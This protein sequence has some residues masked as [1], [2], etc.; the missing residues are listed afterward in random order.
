MT[1]KQQ[2][3]EQVPEA[4]AQPQ[5][6]GPTG[7]GRRKVD[8]GFL[9]KYAVLFVLLGLVV[10]FSIANPQFLTVRNL[11]NI[12]T[13]NTYFIIVAIGLAFV[14]ISGGIDLSVGYQMSLVGVIMAMMMTEWGLPV[15]L[16]L[17]TAI[18]LGTFLGMINGLLVTRIR[19]FPLIVTLATAV[20]FQGISYMVSQARTFRDYPE[21]FQ[22]ITKTR[23]LGIP[24][25]VYLTIAIVVI[26]SIVF[27]Q[28]KWG[29]RV[30]ALGGNEE[31]LRLAGVGT[32]RLKTLV[33][34]TCG[35]FT[36]IAT[37]VMVSKAN[38]MQS[39]FGPG[40]EFTALTA[41]IVGG[42]SFLGGEG[43][44]P[45]LVA[46]VFVL[47]VLGNGMQLAGWSTYAQFIV[48]GIILL[49]AVAFDE[50]QKSLRMK[51]KPR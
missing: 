21:S 46:G 32:R 20:I 16:A 10:L 15:W 6:S 45:A 5:V 24:L 27:Y 19:T 22:A 29:T 35:F 7:A 3:S 44:I 43:N 8:W 38:S 17:L 23:F 33:Y 11:T 26:A 48:R 30:V 42:V 37:I 50:Y 2:D 1:N 25:D 51:T 4:P 31:A 39:S 14:L 49:A 18:V 13:Q 47:A 36:A 40:T 9:R 28:T 34:T 41:A 12:L